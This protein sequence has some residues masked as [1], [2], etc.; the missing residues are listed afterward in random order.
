MFR[1]IKLNKFIRYARHFNTNTKIPIHVL[2]FTTAT[3]KDRATKYVQTISK[4]STLSS[5]PNEINTIDQ[6]DFNAELIKKETIKKLSDEAEKKLNTNVVI[7][8]CL[9]ED[10][11][12]PIDIYIPQY[13]IG[14][15]YVASM[16]SR[17]DLDHSRH[18]MLMVDLVKSPV[19][20]YYYAHS[21]DQKVK[22]F[23][24]FIM[25]DQDNL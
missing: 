9:S 16:H 8:C 24:K 25:A 11:I 13:Q 23:I 19:H 21:S 20:W 2:R 17:Y 14:I 12:M 1:F 6:R 15:M 22:D 3:S 18:R 7:N 10:Q 5:D 4:S